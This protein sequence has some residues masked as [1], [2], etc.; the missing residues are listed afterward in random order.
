M[1]PI[2]TEWRLAEQEAAYHERM[3]EL[4]SDDAMRAYHS[5]MMLEWNEKAVQLYREY[6]RGNH[7]TD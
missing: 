3:A 7:D 4:V 6:V 5:R 1:N 2:L